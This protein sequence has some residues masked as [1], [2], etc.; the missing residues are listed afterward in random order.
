MMLVIFLFR[1]IKEKSLGKDIEFS[2]LNCLS[3][4]VGGSNAVVM[5]RGN[6]VEE[7][8]EWVRFFAE[9]FKFA[10][11]SY[12]T[13]QK[14]IPSMETLNKPDILFEEE[15][16]A[17]AETGDILLFKLSENRFLSD[18]LLGLDRLKPRCRG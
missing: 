18:W 7:A 16:L 9:L 17:E 5:L 6:S 13:E 15:F 8:N 3:F 11:Q 12:H 1:A 4:V 10:K 14:Y 2:G